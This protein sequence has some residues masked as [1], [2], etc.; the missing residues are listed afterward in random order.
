MHIHHY[1]IFSSFLNN[2]SVMVN[3]ILP[4]MIFSFGDYFSYIAGFY[5]MYAMTFTQSKSCIHLLFIGCYS[6]KCFVV[7]N[8]IITLFFSLLIILYQVI[9]LI[10]FNKIKDNFT[11]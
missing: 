11:S 3:H 8:N 6:R 7:H 4:M 10:R 9:V 5:C 1:L 2:F